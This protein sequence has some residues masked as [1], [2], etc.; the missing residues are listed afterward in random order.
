MYRK[1]ISSKNNKEVYCTKCSLTTMS[2]VDTLIIVVYVPPVVLHAFGLLLLYRAKGDLPNQRI[3]TMNL[4]T[5]E[6][7]NCILRVVINSI[8]KSGISSIG[9]MTDNY[10]YNLVDIFI[11][12]SIKLILIHIIV[13]R[14]L[15]VWLNIKYPI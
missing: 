2:W 15:Y 10:Y 5:A 12:A 1:S 6:M 7:F 4:A 8:L 3:T 11:F 14:F 13:D 9:T